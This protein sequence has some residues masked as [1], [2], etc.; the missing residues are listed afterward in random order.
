MCSG[1]ESRRLAEAVSGWGLYF[2]EEDGVL[3][4]LVDISFV[5]VLT[6]LSDNVQRR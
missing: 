4:I 1:P 5:Y 2:L 6:T 3:D